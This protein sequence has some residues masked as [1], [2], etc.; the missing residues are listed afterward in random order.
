VVIIR[1]TKKLHSQLPIRQVSGG[2]D[3][4]LVDWYVNRVVVAR[5]PLLLL[6]SSMSLLPMVVLARDVRSL[7]E[8]LPSIVEARLQQLGVHND[9]IAAELRAMTPVVTAAT[10]DR[11]I[12]GTVNDFA[13]AMPYYLDAAT[14]EPKSLAGLEAWL[15]Q[16]P[17]HSASIG[18]R[19]V[20]PDRKG[21]E[22]LRAK[23]MADTQFPT[24]RHTH[25][26]AKGD[27]TADFNADKKKPERN[28]G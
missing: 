15:A 28:R 11:S 23:W 14:R 10:I 12:L 1:P 18:D 20:F 13:K 24:A 2:S 7:P 6:V 9:L 26:S 16:T 27:D 8:R 4:A 21:P 5:Q 3:T 22:V 25:P 17:C 19:V